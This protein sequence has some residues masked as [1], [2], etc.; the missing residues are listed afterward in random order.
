MLDCLI[1]VVPSDVAVLGVGAVD[2]FVAV[3]ANIQGWLPFALVILQVQA[4]I[5]WLLSTVGSS[6]LV[7]HLAVSVDG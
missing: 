2:K 7:S 4:L 6:S 1:V 5:D 3:I